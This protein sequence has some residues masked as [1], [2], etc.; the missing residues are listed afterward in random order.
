MTGGPRNDPDQTKRGHGI[1]LALERERLDCLDVEGVPSQLE[2]L[3][4]QQ[5][6][7]GSGSLFESSCD[8]DGV[9]RHHA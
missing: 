9:A 6:L 7:A 4:A 5:D 2:R 3:L 8:I 1:G